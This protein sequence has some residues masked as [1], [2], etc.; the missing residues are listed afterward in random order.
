MNEMTTQ[1]CLKDYMDRDEGWG[2]QEGRI[3]FSRLME[4]I[5][6]RPGVQVF[7]FSLDG[8]RRLDIS[9]ASETIVELARRFRGKKGFCFI[10]LNN[11]D[12]LENWDA[13]AER[14]EQPLISWSEGFAQVLGPQPK[15]GAV[16]AFKFAMERQVA[17]AAEYKA[18]REDMSLTINNASMKF[19]QLW[20]EGFLL[21][22][23][24]VSDSGGVEFTYHRIG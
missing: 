13:A 18:A 9:F 17:R 7:K 15:S 12:M 22:R 6:D 21:R 20:Q 3:V 23:E 16:D 5:E 2:R 11:Q 19:K 14:K 8:V 1:V 10:D 4:M 24:S